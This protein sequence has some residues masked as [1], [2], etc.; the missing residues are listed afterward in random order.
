MLTSPNGIC[1]NTTKLS[2]GKFYG[3]IFRKFARVLSL[4]SLYSW[5][6]IEIIGYLDFYQAF[7]KNNDFLI[8]RG[9]NLNELYG[10]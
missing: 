5:K 7:C 8:C 9:S 1:G 10:F 4:F 2:G 6:C 3:K